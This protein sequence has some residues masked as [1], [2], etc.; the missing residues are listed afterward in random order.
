MMCLPL[1]S[2]LLPFFMVH[3]RFR[4]FGRWLQFFSYSF[5]ITFQSR[6]RRR[7]NRRSRSPSPCLTN[8]R[9]RLSVDRLSRGSRFSRFF[10]HRPYWEDS[11]FVFIFSPYFSC[12]CVGSSWCGF[13]PVMGLLRLL[14]HWLH[15]GNSWGL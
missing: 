10:V 3:F 12:L 5:F 1:L 15:S 6:R 9:P 7:R 14:W 11:G 13:T 2:S 4:R 8:L